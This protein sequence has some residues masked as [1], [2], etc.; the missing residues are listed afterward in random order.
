VY[1]DET[2]A[3]AHDGRDTAWVEKDTVAGGTKGGVRCP[4]GKGTRLIILGAG[5]E[6]GWIPN[7][8]LIFR[9]KKNT[10]D[11]HDEM[12]GDHF[13]ECFKDTLL[14]NCL[15]NSLIVMDNASYHSRRVEELPVKSWTKKKMLAWLD[16]KSIPYPSNALKKD[17]L[18]VI[19]G[20]HV[21]TRYKVDEMADAAGHEV[22]C[23]PVAHC[24]LNPIEMTLA[25]ATTTLSQT[26]LVLYR[27]DNP[28]RGNKKA[29]RLIAKGKGRR[30]CKC[31]SCPLVTSSQMII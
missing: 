17:I 1:L 19:E 9:S 8:K 31:G 18:N 11:Y 20:Q 23:L 4:P 10:G 6:M 30:Y 26:L 7:T 16:S 27:N 29:L 22:V 12:T 15:P 3:N 25:Q 2:W 24:T 14:P 21:K 5:G 28:K 13:E